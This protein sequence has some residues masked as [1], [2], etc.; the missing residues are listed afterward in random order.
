MAKAEFDRKKNLFY[1]ETGLY[2]KEETTE[3]LS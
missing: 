3:V 1:K 2:C